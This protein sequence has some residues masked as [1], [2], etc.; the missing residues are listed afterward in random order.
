VDDTMFDVTLMDKF[1][2]F[3]DDSNFDVPDD[4]KYAYYTFISEFCP[5]VS[6]FW[7]HYLNKFC[8][9]ESATFDQ[10]LTR[11]DEAYTFWLIK[12]LYDKCYQHAQYINQFGRD[13]WLEKQKHSRKKGKHDSKAKIDDYVQLLNKIEKHRQDKKSY[14]Y[15]E[16]VFFEKNFEDSSSESSEESDGTKTTN[17]GIENQ[18]I[19][20]SFDW[21]EKLKQNCFYQLFIP[22]INKNY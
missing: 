6:S 11:S 5:T 16:T 2:T 8:K 19:P 18:V 14:S 4:V 17:K 7:K 3:S 1:Y 10:R 22:N 21:K 12:C 13:K 20:Q 15:W 9:I